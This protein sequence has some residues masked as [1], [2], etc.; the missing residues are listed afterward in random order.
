MTAAA[1]NEESDGDRG[2]GGLGRALSPV[3]IEILRGRCERGDME[4]VLELLRGRLLRSGGILVE[5]S[6]CCDWRAVSKLYG[7]AQ[8]SRRN[9]DTRCMARAH[10]NGNEHEVGEL[11]KSAPKRDLFKLLVQ[12][13]GHNFCS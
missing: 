12:C 3:L 4:G 7:Q 2:E 1:C 6:Q 9:R 5:Q 11:P 10:V 13:P 8:S